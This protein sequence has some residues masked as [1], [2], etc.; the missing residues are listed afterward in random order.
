MKTKL[1]LT[2]LA[3]AAAGLALFA[4]ASSGGGSPR[5]MHYA[6]RFSPFELVDNGKRGMS[7]GDQILAHDVLVDNHGTR[8]GRDGLACTVTN[9]AVPES[10]CAGVVWLGDGSVAFEFLNGPPARKLAAITG[11]TGRYRGARGEV[12]IVESA[13][14]QTGTI[15][16]A[17][18]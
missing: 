17:L 4:A 11:G 10:V 1:A 7:D 14:S 8:V 16:I 9:A 3:A 18:D 12:T 2:S 13:K 15:T 6:I 5:T